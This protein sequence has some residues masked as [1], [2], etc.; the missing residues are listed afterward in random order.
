MARKELVYDYGIGL[1]GESGKDFGFV[2]GQS[3]EE[4]IQQ[5][6]NFFEA[7]PIPDADLVGMMQ[8]VDPTYVVT[9]QDQAERQARREL[10][11]RARTNFFKFMHDK[12]S[13]ID[14][15]KVHLERGFDCLLDD[16]GTYEADE[17][18]QEVLRVF[19]LDSKNQYINGTTEERTRVMKQ[20]ID[21]IY[22]QDYSYLFTLS[23]EQLAERFPQMYSVFIM[24]VEGGNAMLN[25]NKGIADPDRVGFELDDEY[26]AKLKSFRDQN[27]GLFAALKNRFDLIMDPSYELIHVERLMPDEDHTPDFAYDENSPY[28][29]ARKSA[30]KR[31]DDA[32]PIY[33]VHYQLNCTLSRV[34]AVATQG[35]LDRANH[36]ARAKGIDPQNVE[37][38][39]ADGSVIDLKNNTN[40]ML[41]VSVFRMTDKDTGKIYALKSDTVHLTEV[42]PENAVNVANETSAAV[43]TA[44]D[45]ADPW[46]IRIFTGSKQFNEMK[47][48]QEA[49]LK[50]RDKMG[51]EPSPERLQEMNDALDILEEKANAY[52]E[53]KGD[54]DTEAKNSERSRIRTAKI[55]LTCV[56]DS[57]VLLDTYVKSLEM[58]NANENPQKQEENVENENQRAIGKFDLQN[59]AD[60]Y[61]A[62]NLEPN[63]P[64]ADLGKQIYD[65]LTTTNA[66]P[67]KPLELLTKMVAFDI[68]A[69]ERYTSV[70]KAGPIEER[71]RANP[72]EFL[73]GLE[74]STTLQK[75]AA[76]L[77]AAGF[78][79]FVGQAVGTAG[80]QKLVNAV[81]SEQARPTHQAQQLANNQLL[82]MQQSLQNQAPE[83]SKPGPMV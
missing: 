64:L 8:A 16:T 73:K 31:L 25:R 11:E 65:E 66:L 14:T 81:T 45:A 42:T 53:Y 2:H 12:I 6:Q 41:G 21:R 43:M 80:I 68:M 74:K 47:K 52:L 26:V 33:P 58:A 77:D 67:E 36:I 9:E 40:S 18:N 63:S 48:A 37:F 57:R 23:D 24:A 32:S 61:K 69:R 62:D 39:R 72:D 28:E 20:F 49:V 44:M 1:V 60:F 83:P 7:T 3:Q 50:L 78:R 34:F 56:N 35:V 15:S 27:Q 76:E 30:L 22:N 29:A 59:A 79:K 17:F 19:A 38:T 13:L 55:A 75:T 46:Y 71:Y 54:I 82:Q 5:L 51:N 70:D 4:T 10:S